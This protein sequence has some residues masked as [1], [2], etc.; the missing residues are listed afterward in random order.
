MTALRTQIRDDV[1]TRLTGLPT[2]GLEVYP[3]DVYMRGA[4]PAIVVRTGAMT[5]S[6]ALG[7]A[8]MVGGD[9][10]NYDLEI[11]LELYSVAEG[12]G[13]WMDDVAEMDVE[14]MAALYA[15]RTLGGLCTHIVRA[16]TPQPVWDDQHEHPAGVMVATYIA[17]INIVGGDLTVNV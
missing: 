4:V 7:G 14:A 11:V 2:A 8:T 12:G 10:E 16:N 1:V 5:P 9:S 15:D 13:A 3:D 6:N 17:E